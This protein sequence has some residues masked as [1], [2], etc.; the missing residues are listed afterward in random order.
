MVDAA[1]PPNEEQQASDADE[2]R[3]LRAALAAHA[4]QSQPRTPT[5]RAIALLFAGMVIVIVAAVG[6]AAWFVMRSPWA[7]EKVA[8]AESK[9]DVAL[10]ERE[11]KR[12]ALDA[13]RARDALNRARYD[14][15]QRGATRAQSRLEEALLP[16]A[17]EWKKRLSELELGDAG[18]GIAS[19][20]VLTLRFAALRDEG[21]PKAPESDAWT[22]RLDAIRKS[23]LAM[24]AHDTLPSPP[25]EEST[26]EL[27]SVG[28][29]IEAGIE[30]YSAAL[31]SLEDLL[32][33]AQAEGLPPA[34]V[35]LHER[36]EQLRNEARVR[37]VET[38]TAK[39]K[40]A[41]AR[42]AEAS[43]ARMERLAA[44]ILAVRREMEEKLAAQEAAHARDLAKL[45]ADG[46]LAKQ[47]QESAAAALETTR[48]AREAAEKEA[49][50]ARAELKKKAET[51]EVREL[52]RP[53]TEPAY[54]QLGSEVVTEEGPLSWSAIAR[55]GFLTADDNGLMRLYDLVF[56]ENNSRSK[57]S[58][59]GI[60][61]K[62][63][64]YTLRDHP[65]RKAFIARAQQTLK[66]LG[67]VLVDM[68]LLRP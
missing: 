9:A 39:L 29:F 18:R 7:R 57:G 62:N 11:Q 42:D 54:F 6:A 10:H 22:G 21:A 26:R 56:H 45:E 61:G 27:Q 33:G 35:S 15:L 59:A 67:P 5:V 13:V 68:H 4:A 37:E 16:L 46:A 40:E 28:G 48:L 50:V 52:L 32:L 58:W 63:S 64:Y 55:G 24:M 8:E 38:F 36:I 19:S 41:T 49:E 65:D 51:S 3:A 2:S 30:T 60:G 1:L 14:D 23:A 66:E 34:P 17:R 31:R 43:E 25:D 44:E 12:A 53:F 47:R 20:D